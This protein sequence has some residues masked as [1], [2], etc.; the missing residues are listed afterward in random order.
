MISVLWQ[1]SCGYAYYQ[2]DPAM[3]EQPTLLHTALHTPA[4]DEALLAGCGRRLSLSVVASRSSG[5][6]PAHRGPLCPAGGSID[7]VCRRCHTEMMDLCHMLAEGPEA[8]GSQGER[9]YTAFH[10]TWT[11]RPP[12]VAVTPKVRA[13]H[14]LEKRSGPGS[15]ALENMLTY[16]KRGALRTEQ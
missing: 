8:F 7:A 1:S 12:P 3:A 9:V 13:S 11:T 5:K 4:V 15:R 2:Y 6:A 14:H 10:T 16:G